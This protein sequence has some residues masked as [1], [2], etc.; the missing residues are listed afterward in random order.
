VNWTLGNKEKSDFG[1]SDIPEKR[2]EETIIP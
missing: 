1:L 2:G